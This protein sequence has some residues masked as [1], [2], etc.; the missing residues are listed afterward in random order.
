MN[1]METEERPYKITINVGQIIASITKKGAIIFCRVSSFGQTGDSSISFDVQEHKG[2]ICANT[3]G[4]RIMGII[5][6]VE[7]VYRGKAWTIRN[8]ITQNQG[9]N[10]IIY[11]VS[12]FS[13]NV[14]TGLELLNYALECN[15]RLFF[16]DEGL[17]WDKNHQTCR[18]ELRN[19]LLLAQEESAAIGRRVK[20]ALAEKKRRGYFTGGIP[21]YGYKVIDA[22]GGRRAVPSEYEQGIIK[23]IHLCR[24][25]QTSVHVLNKWMR[26]LSPN[27][28]H[29][30][31]LEYDGCKV[32]T[33]C[34]PL[35]YQEI[36]YLLN[37]YKVP[38]RKTSWTAGSIGSIA[39]RQH[40]TALGRPATVK[41]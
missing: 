2:K 22:D 41:I 10:I 33:L 20:D 19:K 27:Y 13:R 34:H 9:K 21:K 25:T 4:L 18:G 17:V 6:V 26:R 31:V 16:V 5:K 8:L 28:D 39:K 3:F 14:D 1:L 12:R 23:F 15:T 11:N 30:I 37:D 24:T 40:K 38:K 7:S 35:T 29:H 36:A 32:N